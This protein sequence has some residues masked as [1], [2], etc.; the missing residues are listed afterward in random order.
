MIQSGTIQLIAVGDMCFS[1]H[2]LC[3]GFGVH[4]QIQRHGPDFPLARVAALL[5]EG[6]VVIGNLETALGDPV[7][8]GGGGFLSDSRI[9]EALARNHFDLMSIANNHSLQHGEDIFAET[10][11]HLK[12]NGLGVLGLYGKEG[13][14]CRPVFS[15]VGEQTLAFLGY[16]FAT[17]NFHPDSRSYAR[18]TPEQVMADVGRLKDQVDHVVVSCHWGIEL[19]DGPPPGVVA[20]GRGIIDAGARVVLGHHP[21]VWQGVESY[22]DGVIFYSLGDFVFDLAWCRRC[23][24]T[25]LG[26]IYLSKG[27]PPRWEVVAAKINGKHQPELVSGKEEKSFLDRLERASKQIAEISPGKPLEEAS[28]EFLAEVQKR[29]TANQRA[30]V[31]HVLRN[32]PKLGLKKFWQLARKQVQAN[33]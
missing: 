17:E 14:S 18:S 29:V 19:A 7:V 6:D 8:G 12:K 23:R 4:S 11:S 20:L 31:F 22:H 1:D 10:V 16:S 21:H 5:S 13:Y 30:K 24:D 32:L 33:N 28:G 27:K 15:Q 25:G 2:P 9:A 26:K 3:E